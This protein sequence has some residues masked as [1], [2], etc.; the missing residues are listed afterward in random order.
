MNRACLMFH[1]DAIVFAEQM[2]IRSQV[3]YKQEYLADLLTADCIYGFAEL[4]DDAG[5]ALIVP[6][7]QTVLLPYGGAF[8]M[9][10]D[11]GSYR[12][13]YGILEYND[14]EGSA[15][16]DNKEYGQRIGKYGS[17]PVE[18]DITSRHKLEQKYG[19]YS[20]LET[21]IDEEGIRNPIFCQS[22]EEGTFG[23]YGLSRL[24]IARRKRIPIPC[25]IADYVERWS[26]LEEL[27]TKDDIRAKYID[28]PTIIDLEET[29]MK[30]AGCEQMHLD[31]E[32]RDFF[33]RR[34]TQNQQRLQGNK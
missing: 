28:K 1:K 21:S 33:Y 26:D 22:I 15:L 23:K 14:I 11:S 6:S 29:F 2:A 10:P 3:Q 8:P 9:S 5:L 17:R 4:R 20:K 18:P 25:I 12:I 16:V 13:F 30:I 34:A 27:F 19:F 31:E 32:D 7:I 24:W